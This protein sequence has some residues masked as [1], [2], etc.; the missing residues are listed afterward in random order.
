MQLGSMLTR[1]NTFTC[2]T[3]RDNVF[4]W[5][6]RKT[7]VPKGEIQTDWRERSEVSTRQ[8]GRNRKLRRTKKRKK[9]AEARRKAENICLY[10]LHHQDFLYTLKPIQKTKRSK[11][12][13]LPKDISDRI[14]KASSWLGES[15]TEGG[16]DRYKSCEELLQIKININ[17]VHSS[18]Y[19]ERLPPHRPSP[20]A[21]KPKGRQQYKSHQNYKSEHHLWVVFLHFHLNVHPMNY[22]VQ[23]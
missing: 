18:K 8:D 3:K 9:K 11:C 5:Q 17:T 15:L 10:S 20:K 16:E 6:H 13:N 2:W 22:W 12:S 23:T 21:E 1:W 4:T 19:L 7:D 14:Q